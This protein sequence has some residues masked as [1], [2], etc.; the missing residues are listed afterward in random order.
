MAGGE[1]VVWKSSV[2]QNPPLGFA[3][4]QLENYIGFSPHPEEKADRIQSPPTQPQP[5]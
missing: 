2:Y 1:A 5:V 3:L 4:W